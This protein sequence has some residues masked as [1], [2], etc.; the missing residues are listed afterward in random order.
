MLFRCGWTFCGIRSAA[1]DSRRTRIL[2][3]LELHF[4]GAIAAAN[5]RL[6][7]RNGSNRRRDLDGPADVRTI[8]DDKRT[9]HGSPVWPTGRCQMSPH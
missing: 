5:E 6:E 8:I 7:D 9:A 1:S 3:W 4:C 2:L